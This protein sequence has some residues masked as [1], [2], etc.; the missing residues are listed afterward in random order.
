MTAAASLRMSLIAVTAAASLRKSLIAVTAAASLREGLI[1]MI[2]SFHLLACTQIFC[3][4]I[5]SESS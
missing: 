5:L 3:K 1:A 2:A 4:L